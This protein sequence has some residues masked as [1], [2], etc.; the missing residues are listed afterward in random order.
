MRRVILSGLWARRRRLLG[1][2]LAV[3]LGTAFLAGT[4]MLSGTLRAN[5]ERLFSD[6]NAG[7]DAVVRSVASVETDRGPARAPI[8]ESL[9]ARIRALDGVAAAAPLVEGYGQVRGRD[10]EAVGGNGPPRIAASWVEPA[11]LSGYELAAGRAPRAP[12]EAVLNRG[13]AEAGGLRI[14]DETVVETPEP[15]RVR[16]VGLATFAGEDGFG[17]S[18][19]AAFTL[20]EA[21]R[22]LAGGAGRVSEIRVAAGPGVSQEELVARVA[23]VLPGGVEAVT[24]AQAADED[25]A[26]VTGDFV[27]AFEI[28][29]LVFAGIVLLVAAFSIAN[30]LSIVVAQRT[31]ESALLRAVGASRG[32]VRGAV[33]AEAGAIG[34]VA[35]LAGVAGGLAIASALKA[36]IAAAGASPPLDGLA[37]SP[38]VVAIPVAVG[39]GVTVLAGLA[40]ARR[41]ARVAPV[42]AMREADAGEPAG[43]G[44][45]GAAVRGLGALLA[46]AGALRGVPGTLA[47]ANAARSPRRALRTASALIAGVGVVTLITVFAASLKTSTLDRVE[48]SFGGDLAVSAPGFGGGALPPSL[49]ER[50]ARLPEVDGAAALG[51]G[52]ARL[53]GDSRPITGADPRSLARV[54]DLD[55][56][57]GSVERLAGEELAVSRDLAQERG[58]RVGSAVPVAF[59]DG[60]RAE[61]RVGAVYGRDDVVGDVVIP[62]AT[63]ARHAVQPLDRAVLV[64]LAPGVGEAQGRRAVQTV[65]R[66]MGDPDVQ[67]RAEYV[68]AQAG[69]LDV[70]LGMVYVLLALAIV[71]ALMGIANTLSLATHE[72][73][74]ELGLLRAVGATREQ[75]RAM[76]RGEGLVVATLGALGG[77][78]A[79]VAAAGA[80]I[81]AVGDG[82]GVTTLS[83]P[84]ARLAIVVVVGALAGTLAAVRPARRAARLDPLR[85]IG[86]AV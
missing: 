13:A 16:V 57:A 62:R 74:R 1:T 59:A 15:V 79:G 12:G 85:A 73:R 3:F 17:E 6:A 75:V 64:T 23:A 14:G 11:A 53:G 83:L 33:V 9:A 41:A 81:L 8:D 21:Q 27:D 45:L 67:T 19:Y 82:A 69:P 65:T 37:L 48:A 29:L 54:L 40:P 70:A 38:A 43:R 22:L 10:G 36:L 66:A 39:V 7:T 77:V 50:V 28:V 30:T 20:D 56:T 35:S 68:E 72:R 58:W 44:P 76:V 26:D 49:A 42:T 34:L 46:R 31:R 86:G 51:T 55:V 25:L 2:S 78:V 32:Q 80:L 63:S 18:T 60:T 71:I 24:G 52:S 47:R 84:G 5:F 4:L 61:L